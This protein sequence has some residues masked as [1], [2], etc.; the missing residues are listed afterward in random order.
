MA[1]FT[2]ELRKVLE[3]G[4]D[5][6]LNDYPIFEESYRPKLNKSITEHFAYREIGFETIDM[7][8][9]RFRQRM[10]LLMPVY[11]KLFK[12]TLMEFDP[13]TTTKIV[14][15]S[16]GKGTE[17]GTANSTNTSDA[18]T[19][20]DSTSKSRSVASDYPQ[21]M[22]A[23][24]GD[25][26]TSA[27]DSVSESG[28]QSTTTEAGSQESVQ[29]GERDSQS[30]T[31]MEGYTRSPAELVLLYRETLINVDAMLIA[32]LEPLFMQL[33]NNSDEYG[34]YPS[35]YFYGSFFGGMF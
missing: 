9:N 13:L 10:N 24:G 25:Y 4:I 21:T 8:G 28:V 2:I 30:H 22:L 6:G 15:D 17:T 7:F 3:R 33:W 16:E 31:T 19:G 32:D 14:T 12:S 26:A 34:D 35:T 18:S 5:I 23:E 20:T 29:A 1:T 11:N 27:S